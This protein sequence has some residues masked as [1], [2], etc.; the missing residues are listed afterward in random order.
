MLVA[1]ELNFSNWQEHAS[2]PE[3]IAKVVKSGDRLILFA[4]EKQVFFAV[5]SIT[6]AAVKPK[7]RDLPA[8][9]PSDA[10][11]RYFPLEIDT[12]IPNLDTAVPIGS[13]EPEGYAQEWF[14]RL[15]SV[16]GQHLIL[17]VVEEYASNHQTSKKKTNLRYL[18]NYLPMRKS[19]FI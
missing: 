14:G 18:L 7:K 2:A 1:E 9:K 10:K 11:L 13:V 4:V 12:Y 16:A 19:I 17:S 5:A 3:E 6:G 15:W 8:G